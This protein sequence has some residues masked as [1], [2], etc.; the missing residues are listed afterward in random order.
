MSQV[1]DWKLELFSDLVHSAIRGNDCEQWRKALPLLLDEF[2][3]LLCDALELSRELRGANGQRDGSCWEL[4]SIA[5]HDQNRDLRNG[6][7]VLIELLRDAWLAVKDDNPT[8]AGRIAERWFGIPYPA[9]KR[10]AFY[11]ASQNDCIDAAQWTDWLLSDS[12]WWLWSMETRREVMRLLTLRGKNLSPSQ[13]DLENAILGGP[14]RDMFR[15]D[16]EPGKW[17][18]IVD[19][20]IWMRLAKLQASGLGLGATAKSRLESLSGENPSWKLHS[21][22]REEFAVWMSGTGYPDYEEDR[23]MNEAPRNRRDLVQWLESPVRR[24]RQSDDDGWRDRCRTRFFHCFL[25]LRDL[26]VEGNWPADRWQTALQVWSGKEHAKRSWNFAGPLVREMPDET[27]RDIAHGVAWWLDSTSGTIE[28]HEI[29]FLRLCRRILYLPLE[30]ESDALDEGEPIERPVVF[31]INHPVGLAT[32]A[33]LKFW[34]VRGEPNDDDGLA[35]EIAPLFTEICDT[36]VGR[37]RHGRVVLA[38]HLIPLFRIDRK[39]TGKH[40]LPLFQWSDNSEE[41]RAV[42]EGFLRSQRLHQPLLIAIKEQFLQT[43]RHFDKLIENGRLYAALL[44]HAALARIDGFELEEFRLAFH[45]LPPK[46]LLASS[47]TLAQALDSAGEQREEYWANRV[48]PFW[49][50]VWPKSKDLVSEDIAEQLA[51]ASI[52]SGGKF[53]EALELFRGWLRPLDYFEHVVLSL[54]DSNLCATSPGEVLHLLDT[55]VEKRPWCPSELMQ[56]L[57]TISE[58][59]PNLRNDPRFQRLMGH[60]ANMQEVAV[61]RIP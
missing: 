12:S 28:N 14:P 38:S 44:T 56:C 22:G 20:G 40:L 36:G 32:Q 24:S 26:T 61:R 35:G 52:V 1:A 18:E 42:W 45:A 7:S 16:L 58:A 6:W 60:A 5:P 10:L 46:G 15:E 34:L 30:H 9:F 54:L 53:R 49:K 41:T 43:A 31:A 57:T 4:P 47:E 19:H 11:A 13:A 23:R 2:Q 55:L 29:G 33:A 50:G 48:E 8:K 39:W 17:R 51:Y 59:D 3:Q 25:A 21:L 37:F 27:L